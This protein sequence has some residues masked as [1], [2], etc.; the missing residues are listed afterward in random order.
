MKKTIIFLVA[1]FLFP[2]ITYSANV[3]TPNVGK[4]LKLNAF[5]EY[6]EGD[7]ILYFDTGVAECP[8]ALWLSPS[9]HGF[10]TVLSLAI[11]AYTTQKDVYFGVHNDKIFVGGLDACKI[12][13]IRFD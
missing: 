12:D 2:T 8:T 13:S 6:G 9:S 11:T 5:A 4:I 1:I 10:N 7:V 3:N